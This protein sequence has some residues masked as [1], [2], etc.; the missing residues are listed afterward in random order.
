MPAPARRPG[1]S[2]GEL[3]S[4]RWAPA[5]LLGSHVSQPPSPSLYVIAQAAKESIGGSPCLFLAEFTPTA[6]ASIGSMWRFITLGSFRGSTACPSRAW[7][8]TESAGS[9][10]RTRALIGVCQAGSLFSRALC[11]AFR[12]NDFCNV[13][14][15]C[16][17]SR[18][19]QAVFWA[20]ELALLGV[21]VRLA[22][23][24]VFAGA[25]GG[26]AQLARYFR[27]GNCVSF[28]SPAFSD[29]VKIGAHCCL[30][31]C[32]H[33]PSRFVDAV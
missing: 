18:L 25:S 20:D 12:S 17:A 33:E 22:R 30:G 24:A 27:L 6:R 9:L 21:F 5:P 11:Q 4:F 32:A 14:R 7:R 28:E 15:W 19:G 3:V 2:R 8:R 13:G 29:V 23:V 26:A 16:G 1:L 31:L 10:T